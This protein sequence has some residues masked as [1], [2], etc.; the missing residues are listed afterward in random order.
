MDVAAVGHDEAFRAVHPISAVA[1][2]HRGLYN[3][4][5]GDVLRKPGCL[6]GPHGDLPID[7][8]GT[9]SKLTTASDALQVENFA[10]T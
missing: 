10:L 3:A 4:L 6:L 9:A 1:S 7:D 5:F 2:R 8:V